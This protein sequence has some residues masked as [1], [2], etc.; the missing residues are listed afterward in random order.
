MLVRIALLGLAAVH[1]AEPAQAQGQLIEVIYSISK[2]FMKL[3]EYISKASERDTKGLVKR[4]QIPLDPPRPSY[5]INQSDIT[6]FLHHSLLSICSQSFVEQGNCF[7]KD[8]FHDATIFENKTLDSQ[9]AVVVDRENKLVVV[10]Y[11]MSTTDK[12]WD[13]NEDSGLVSYPFT[14]GQEMVHKGH[15]KHYRSIQQP[16]EKRALELLKDPRHKDYTLHI[17]GYSLG[18]S[19]TAISMPVWLNLLEKNGLKNKARFFA[20]SNPRPG[21]LAFA[22][23]IETLGAPIVRYAKKGDIVPQIPEQA[24]GYSQ[25]GQEFYDPDDMLF[26]TTHLKRC[27]PN[28]IQDGSCSLNNNNFFPPHHLLPFNKPIP[29]PPFCIPP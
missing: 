24:V 18:G 5:D 4:D 17:T 6:N 28:V 9:A 22:Q 23:Y 21:N 14:N 3:G 27:S 12:N 19:V 15:L 25:I 7:C 26:A 1:C 13:T 10:S 2:S 20:Y 8:R 11:R 29:F 16:T